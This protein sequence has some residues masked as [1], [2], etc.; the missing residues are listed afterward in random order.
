MNRLPD[1]LWIFT[2]AGNVCVPVF[3]EPYFPPDAENLRSVH[4]YIFA[5]GVPV[6]KWHE[7]RA[8]I[9]VERVSEIRSLYNLFTLWMF[10]LRWQIES[11][12]TPSPTCEIGTLILPYARDYSLYIGL[13]PAEPDIVSLSLTSTPQT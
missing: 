8:I 4:Q 12:V 2:P 13:T 11:G 5:A 6:A 10:I 1:K 9:G 3:F 7:W